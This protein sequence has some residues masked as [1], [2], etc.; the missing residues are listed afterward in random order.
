[1]GLAASQ[2]RFLGL[3]ARKSNVE[4]QG[5][6]INQQRTALSNEIL[7][8][9][10]EYNKLEVPTPPVLQD[11][12]K[13]TY[14]M[15]DTAKGYQVENVNKLISGEYE[16][17]YQVDL[18]YQEAIPKAY[19]YMANGVVTTFAQNGDKTTCSISIGTEKFLYDD[20]NPD[21]SNMKKIPV[22]SDISAL[23]DESL[24]L[25]LQA[26]NWGEGNYYAFVMGGKTYYASESEL[27]GF[28]EVPETPTAGTDYSGH[29]DYSFAY[30]GELKVDKTIKAIAALTQNNQGRMSA[31]QIVKCEEDS[32]LEDKAFSVATQ[33]EDDQLRYDDAMNKYYYDK[34]LYEKEVER[35]NKKTETKQKEDRSL[36]LQLSQLETEQQALAKE[37]DSV[38]KV[39]EETIEKVFKTFSS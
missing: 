13:V 2:A 4:Y 14:T 39:V 10:N 20:N 27:K 9:Y 26:N 38:S 7:G 19:D 8:L 6:Q 30:Q 5:Q 33:T 3:T 18:A 34:A 21:E 28:C 1:M 35:I 36:E 11:F 23:K 24:K 37:M 16:G 31:I 29:G 15:T 22:G 25:I 32:A 17:F 12:S